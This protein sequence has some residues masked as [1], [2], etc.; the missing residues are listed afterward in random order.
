M[1]K[2]TKKESNN[3][4]KAK[5]AVE[6]LEAKLIPLRLAYARELLNAEW[7]RMEKEYSNHLDFEYLVMDLEHDCVSQHDYEEH[8]KK[9]KMEIEGFEAYYHR[10]LR[11]YL[12]YHLDS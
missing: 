3:L 10:I 9:G 8:Y 2:T 1:T 7:D 4:I 11:H 5:E 12:S 6:K